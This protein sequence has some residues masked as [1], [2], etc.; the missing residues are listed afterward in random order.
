MRLGS[1]PSD[2]PPSNVGH[3]AASP[4]GRGQMLSSELRRD[5]HYAER[6]GHVAS[7][8]LGRPIAVSSMF[9]MRRR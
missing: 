1:M 4:A 3:W 8:T 5:V 2:E 6:S 7:T 9:A